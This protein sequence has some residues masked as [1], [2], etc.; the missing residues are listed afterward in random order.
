MGATIAEFQAKGF[1]IWRGLGEFNVRE[2]GHGL[3]GETS[4]MGRLR[5][6]TQKDA[7]PTSTGAASTDVGQTVCR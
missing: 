2:I 4:M 1:E 3:G 5:E 7:E 6:S